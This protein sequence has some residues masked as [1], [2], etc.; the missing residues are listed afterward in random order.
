MKEKAVSQRILLEAAQRD[1]WL[2]RNNSGGF[3][4]ETGRF[5]RYGLGG[6]T[7]ADALASSDYIGWTPVFIMPEMVG[8]ILPV[9][10]A[11]ETKPQGWKFNNSVKRELHQSNF[12]DMIRN[13]GGKA[14]FAQ[15][16]EDFRK[17]ID[18]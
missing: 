7:E 12:I 11:I 6:F 1:M 2:G 13:A 4:D 5:V 10:T 3:Y 9:F 15:S 8:R 16:V 17:I 14:G 18:E